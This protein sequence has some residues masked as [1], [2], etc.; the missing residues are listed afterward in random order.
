MIVKYYIFELNAMPEIA[1]EDGVHRLE[2][3]D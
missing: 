1:H 2:I 3:K